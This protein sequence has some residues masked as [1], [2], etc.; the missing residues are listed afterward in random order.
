MTNHDTANA[1]PLNV[2]IG[3]AYSGEGREAFRRRGH[4]AYSVDLLPADDG[5]P[6]HI[7]GDIRDAIQAGPPGQ[8]TYTWELL[9]AHPPCTALCVSGNHKYAAGKPAHYER[10]DSMAW[11]SNLWALALDHC[12]RICFENSRG[13]LARTAMG[14]PTQ[15]IQPHQ[16]GHDASK[17]TDLWLHF[18]PTLAG[19]QEVAPRWVDNK[20]RWAN[21]TDSGQN[22]LGPSAT[23]W[24]ERARTYSGIAAAMADQW[25]SA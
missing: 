11:T 20:P 24:K 21:Q 25:G 18:L 13:V 22:R 8:L 9:I 23:R 14:K 16:F 3:C 7:Q 4:N 19:T 5:S 6:Y 2:L 10:L 17:T 1:D 12:V 15:T